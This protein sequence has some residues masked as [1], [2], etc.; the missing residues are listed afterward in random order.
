[1]YLYA[2]ENYIK[3][4]GEKNY[5]CKLRIRKVMIVQMVIVIDGLEKRL[6]QQ[7]DL[8][9]TT[10]VELSSSAKNKRWIVQNAQPPDCLEID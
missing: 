3:K 4:T 5:W 9:C 8:L 1:M 7:K 2:F 6:N 10:I